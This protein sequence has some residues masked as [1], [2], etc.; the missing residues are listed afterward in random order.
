MRITNDT[1][2]VPHNSIGAA[3]ATRIVT[4][5]A[6]QTLVELDLDFL[7]LRLAE[8]GLA[9]AVGALRAAAPAAWAHY[10]ARVDTGIGHEQLWRELMTALLAGAGVRERVAAT[11]EWLRS[12][13]PR[14]NLFRAPIADMIALVRELVA[15]GV[16]V[17]VLSNSEGRLAE[18]LDEVGIAC[19]FAAIIDSG[20]VG[21]EKPDPRIFA[22]ALAVLRGDGPAVHVGDSWT[23]DVQGALAAGWRAIWYGSRTH[24]VE[25]VRV[26]VA[27]DA[28]GVRAALAAWA[29]I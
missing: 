12:E 4:F 16:R 28:A 23:T 17:A 14:R 3:L 26:A 8:Q 22:H 24:A 27:R 20:R 25:D 1:L 10:E 11:V 6:G 7:A 9:V 18:L 19:D 29:V 2:S 13:Q 21:I 15:A 5:D